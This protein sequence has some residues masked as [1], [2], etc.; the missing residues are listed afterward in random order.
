MVDQLYDPIM[1]TQ[2][3]EQ[4]DLVQVIGDSLGVGTIQ[5]NSF[6]SKD[7]SVSWL[8]NRINLGGTSL[9]EKAD[10]FVFLAIKL[11]SSNDDISYTC[12][13]KRIPLEMDLRLVLFSQQARSR[14]ELQLPSR[15]NNFEVEQAVPFYPTGE[16]HNLA[17][18]VK[19][20]LVQ[21]SGT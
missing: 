17:L 4:V 18:V 15:Y 16:Q 13:D 5:L 12:R 7:L 2:P 8:Q 14:R 9:A 6:E 20:Q 10:P 1:S 19:V 3:F 11:Y 21:E